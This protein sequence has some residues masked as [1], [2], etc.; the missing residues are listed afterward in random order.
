MKKEDL[1]NDD[2]LKQFKDGDDLNDFL[3]QLQKRGIEKMLEGELDG[4]LGYSKN[5]KS[6][7]SNARNGYSE[8]KVRTSSS[9]AFVT[10]AFIV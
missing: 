3:K 8:K 1:L 2:F 6:D 4:H 5:Q 7:N 9:R 10:H